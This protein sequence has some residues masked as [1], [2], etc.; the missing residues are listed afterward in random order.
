MIFTARQLQEKAR[1]QQC[2][3]YMCF[4]DL[5]KAYDSVP[6]DALWLLLGRW[7]FPPKLVNILKNMH[8]GMKAS[9]RVNGILSDPFRV[10]NGLKQGCVLAPFLFNLYFNLYFNKVMQDALDGFN[11]GFQVKYKLDGKLFRRSGTKLPMSVNICDLRF[12]DDVMASCHNDDALQAFI[13]RFTHAA[14]SWGLSVST[15]KT[16]VMVQL[17]PNISATSTNLFYI[18]NSVSE[19]SCIF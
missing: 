12:A 1:E 2:Q 4:F 17:P 9:V 8:S 19:F 6:R 14:Q 10:S 11:E 13:N 5:K 3:L 15:E 18:E 7:G 16:K